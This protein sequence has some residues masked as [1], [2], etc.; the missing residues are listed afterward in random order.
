M[1]NALF[2]VTIWNQCFTSLNFLQEE[3]VGTKNE[4]NKYIYYEIVDL[5]QKK[6]SQEFVQIGHFAFRNLIYAYF[7]EQELH[8][9]T[10]FRYRIHTCTRIFGTW[11]AIK[12]V[13]QYIQ[14]KNIDYLTPQLCLKVICAAYHAHTRTYICVSAYHWLNAWYLR[15]FM[16]YS[17]PF[18]KLTTSE[19]ELDQ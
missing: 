11:F 15:I 16:L 14:K 13:L 8:S 1:S 3:S 10:M 18:S 4:I 6:N 12:L 17:A 7:D 5:R 2:N 19:H 9:R